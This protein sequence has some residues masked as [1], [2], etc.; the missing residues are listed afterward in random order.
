ML[1]LTTVKSYY[2]GVPGFRMKQ[3]RL[4]YGYPSSS[5]FS[6]TEHGAG[7]G[8]TYLRTGLMTIMSSYLTPSDDIEQFKTKVGFIQDRVPAIGGWFVVAGDFN[9]KAVE[10][11]GRTTN[12][13][14]RYILD[15]A[16]RLDL[17]VMNTGSISTFKRSGCKYTTPDINLVTE[18]L[19]S[20]IAKWKVLEDYNGSDH[21]YIVFE[22]GN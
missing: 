18:N 13:Q 16:A 12:A 11:G 19:T 3:A 15:A 22:S 1:V 21:H 4:H 8:Y 2:T 14:G 20:E 6:V 17:M 10:W 7:F 9:A 5:R